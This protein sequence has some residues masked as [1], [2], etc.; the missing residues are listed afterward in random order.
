VGQRPSAG[1]GSRQY[2]KIQGK[3]KDKRPRVTQPGYI[4]GINVDFISIGITV[5]G[6]IYLGIMELSKEMT[7]EDYLRHSITTGQ[8]GTGRQVH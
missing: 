6:L 5:V 7:I 3:A 2:K 4:G 1:A 8:T